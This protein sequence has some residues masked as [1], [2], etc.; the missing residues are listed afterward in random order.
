[1][2]CRNCGEQMNENQAICLKCGVKKG[3]GNSFCKNCGKAVD[4]NASV[5]VAC[6][7]ALDTKYEKLK[8]KITNLFS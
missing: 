1:M 7:F 2:Y 3:D 4:Q 6:G 8:K 5:C